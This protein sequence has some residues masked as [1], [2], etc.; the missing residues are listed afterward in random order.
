MSRS[1]LPIG[2]HSYTEVLEAITVGTYRFAHVRTL[3]GRLC[4]LIGVSPE[5]L[6]VIRAEGTRLRFSLA[7]LGS[8]VVGP[9]T[10]QRTLHPVLQSRRVQPVTTRLPSLTLPGSSGTPIPK[11]AIKEL[12]WSEPRTSDLTLFVCDTRAR[13]V[14]VALGS[15]FETS[16]NRTLHV[17]F[18]IRVFVE[19]H[20]HV[21]RSAT[22]VRHCIG[23]HL[24]RPDLPADHKFA[25][26]EIDSAADCVFAMLEPP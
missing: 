22:D 23:Q 12:G 16:L 25:Q 1:T 8:R 10:F 13:A 17:G 18:P 20:D 24:I 4:P 3:A 15:E 11:D 19:L 2:F 6:D 21:F 14:V 7:L 9:R 5:Q 26:D